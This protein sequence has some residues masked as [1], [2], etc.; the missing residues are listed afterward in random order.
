MSKNNFTQTH[1]HLCCFH[2]LTTFPYILTLPSILTIFPQLG[3]IVC[4]LVFCFYIEMKELC[5]ARVNLEMSSY[6]QIKFPQID[7]PLKLPV[8]GVNS[9]LIYVVNENPFE[10][11]N[12]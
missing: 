3:D 8:K 4:L 5:E 12:L 9:L 2:H 6:F 1:L 7:P 10:T 11:I